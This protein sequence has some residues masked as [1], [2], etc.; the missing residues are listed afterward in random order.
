MD[1]EKLTAAHKARVDTPDELK[2]AVTL[3]RKRESSGASEEELGELHGKIQLLHAQQKKDT[4][5]MREERTPA[6]YQGRD[7]F[8]L[9]TK[10]D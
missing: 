6:K 4:I 3:Y 9:I 2:A 5:R 1:A 10:P 7:Q 8:K